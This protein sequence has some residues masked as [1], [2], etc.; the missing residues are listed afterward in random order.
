MT[1]VAARVAR[2]RARIADAATRRGRRPEEVTLVVVT[3]GVEV[4]R[5]REALACGITD[6]G[7]NRVQEAVP[8]VAAVGRAVRWHLIGHLQRN[9]VRQAISL[10]NIVQS[11]DSQRLAVEL[12]QYAPSPIDVLLQVNVAGESQKFGIRPDEASELVPGILTLPG[13]RLVGLMTI[14]PQSSDPEAVR[15]VFRQLRQLRDELAGL[16]ID[17]LRLSELSMGMTDDFEVAVEEGATLVRIGRAI[18]GER[19]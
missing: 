15:P 7:E 9:K 5:I 1:D 16:G 10:F 14:A 11:L 6:V 2:V 17:G 3:K 4:A 12:N 8:K 13:L 19:P 18:F